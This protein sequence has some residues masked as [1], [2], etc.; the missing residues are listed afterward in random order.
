MDHDLIKTAAE[1]LLWLKTE[2][3]KDID[4]ATL[5]IASPILYRLLTEA[6]LARAAKEI[7]YGRL[8][9]MVP[10]S[11][12]RAPLGDS[13]V[14][15]WQSGGATH[16]GMFIETMTLRKGAMSRETIA[17][18]A[19]E[20][21][22]LSRTQY[23]QTIEVFLDSPAFIVAGTAISRRDVIGYVNNKK[24]GRHYD[25]QRK[26]TV[27]DARYR[28]LDTIG[29]EITVADKNAVYFEMLSIGQRLVNNR[30][31]EKLIKKLGEELG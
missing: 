30:D 16:R 27:R 17:K 15:F 23:P 7:G 5:R 21:N 9:I 3:N 11:C 26:D 13:E 12:R 25:T 2:W 28:L 24:G 14:V 8:R 4:D 1:D 19:A 29:S 6:L 20:L 10:E 18:R 31:I 22:K